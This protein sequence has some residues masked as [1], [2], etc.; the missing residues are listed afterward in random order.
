VKPA[1][2]SLHV[3]FVQDTCGGRSRS[4]PL[5]SIVVVGGGGRGGGRTDAVGNGGG[6]GDCGSPTNDRTSSSSKADC[7]STSST[8]VVVTQSEDDQ[9]GGWARSWDI[10]GRPLP[11]TIT[12]SSVNNT[13]HHH[14]VELEGIQ[15][16]KTHTR[17]LKNIFPGPHLTCMPIFYMHTWN[18]KSPWHA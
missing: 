3:M 16:V 8:A 4:E 14:N 17:R 15:W 1:T 13:S 7:T 2:K 11:D 12:P 10:N 9:A 5:R 18:Y 6:G